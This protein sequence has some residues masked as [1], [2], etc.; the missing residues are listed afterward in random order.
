MLPRRMRPWGA[1]ALVAVSV[2]VGGVYYLR[3]PLDRLD[4]ARLRI[5]RQNWRSAGI[6][7]YHAT[8]EMAGGVY[9]VDVRVGRIATLEL[10]DGPVTTSEPERFT[11]DGLFDVLEMEL[12]AFDS[13]DDADRTAGDATAADTAEPGRHAIMRVRFHPKLGYVERYLRTVTGSGRTH[14]IEMKSF[15]TVEPRQ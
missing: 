3:E 13:P 9:R 12:D 8:Y 1:T 4:G 7:N 14:G 11:I 10:D 6:H 5:A 15:S 2:V